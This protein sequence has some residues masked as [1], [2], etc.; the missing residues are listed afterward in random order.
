VKRMY[1]EADDLTPLITWLK[2]KPEG[3]L[4]ILVGNAGKDT[5][6]N[7]MAG[8]TKEGRDLAAWV[9]KKIRTKQL[10][11]ASTPEKLDALPKNEVVED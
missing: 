8:I 9:A 10:E 7:V 1:V 11:I 2:T 6:Q 5:V 3:D 4:R